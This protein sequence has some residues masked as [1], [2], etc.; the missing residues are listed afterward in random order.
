MMDMLVFLQTVNR[1]CALPAT[2]LFFGSAIFIS[3][4]T[5]FPQFFAFH[6]LKRIVSKLYSDDTEQPLKEGKVKTKKTIAPL[7]A[8]YAAMGTTIG[9]GNIVGPALAIFSG[10]P[11]ALF[12]LLVYIFF[13]SVIKYAEVV[14]A[15]KT[16][17]ISKDGNVIGGPMEYLKLVS[18]ILAIS[19]TYAMI[20]LF[21]GWSSVQAN[22]LASFLS[23]YYVPSWI[24]GATVAGLVVLVL[25]GGAERVGLVASYVVPLMFIGYV[26]SILII[27]V[28]N[29]DASMQAFMLMG[30]CIFSPAAPLGGFAGAS[31]FYAM[32]SGVYRSIFIS[33]AGLGTSAITHAVADVKDPVDQGVLAL[34]S[35][36]SDALLSFLSG[37]LV[38]STGVWTYGDF[39]STLI[40]EAFLHH[41]SWIGQLILFI[42]VFLFVITTVIGNSFNGLQSFSSITNHKQKT[43]YTTC[44]ALAIL[45]GSVARAQMIW[46]LMDVVLTVVALFNLLG[47]VWLVYH[48]R[49]FLRI[50]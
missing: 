40:Y 49:S 26:G 3:F 19:Y 20:P 34:Y 9:V 16:R 35:M 6:R 10:G 39:R 13:G 23:M 30:R 43:F 31:V 8:L 48:H 44:T 32:R 18:P 50:D 42:T 24:V 46:E 36:G 1:I 25:R 21:I 15:I 27:L 45:A 12:W 41:A 28:R 29:I 5:S 37:M 22:T 47:L 4:L 11:G 38:L 2:V 17:I 7:H 33:E 14:F